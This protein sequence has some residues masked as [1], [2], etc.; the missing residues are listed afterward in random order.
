M[1]IVHLDLAGFHTENMLYQTNLLAKY[2]RQDGHEVTI[3]TTNY[4]WEGAE[5]VQVP[6]CDYIAEDDV[7]LIRLS[8]A[9]PS[10]NFHRQKFRKVIGLY[11]TLTMLCPDVILCHCTQFYSIL[12]VIR[13]KKEHPQVKLYADTH[14]AY[15]N[16]GT[17]ALSLHILHKIYYKWLTQKALPYL[18]KY[19]YI[20]EGEHIFAREVYGV[21][22]DLME[23]Y[24]LGGVLPTDEEYA[25]RRAAR[26]AELGVPENGLLF[27]HSGKLEPKKRTADLLTAF[28]A[29]PEL[30]ATLAVIGSIPEE[31]KPTL[32]PMMEKD[33]RVKYLGWKTGAELQ[34]YLCACDLYCQPGKVSAIYQNALCCRVG[35]MLYPHLPYTMHYEYGQ[36]LWVEG[37]ED[38]T[39]AFRRI[40]SGELDVQALR[41]GAMRCARELLDYRALAARLYR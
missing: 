40:A 23:F 2:N 35:A 13:Y 7:R 15:D 31:L 38:M 6:T 1:K 9:N 27:V 14:T 33:K 41:T 30:D 16:S 20:G 4:R 5:I 39:A 29:V 12:D 37:A 36:N 3:V 11:P 22:E 10:A 8:Y 17:N 32:L 19:F 34:E 24:P 25:A 18:E 21:P 26:R 28:A